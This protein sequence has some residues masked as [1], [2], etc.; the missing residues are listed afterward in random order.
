MTESV[1][2]KARGR[3]VAAENTVAKGYATMRDR[4]VSPA[5]A[6]ADDEEQGRIE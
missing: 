2:P 5:P 1:K 6:G 3:E 4:L